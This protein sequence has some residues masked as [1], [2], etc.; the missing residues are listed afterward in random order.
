[1][2]KKI[3]NGVSSKVKEEEKELGERVATLAHIQA[4][5]M[6]PAALSYSGVSPHSGKF[7]RKRFS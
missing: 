4:R 7:K 3:I 6:L 2:P 5:Q 1:M